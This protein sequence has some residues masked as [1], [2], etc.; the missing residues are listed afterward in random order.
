MPDLDRPGTYQELDL[1]NMRQRLAGFASQCE[2]AWEE[3]LA[4][5]LPP[6]YARVERAVVVGMGGSAIGGD[7]LADLASQEDALPIVVSRDYHAPSYV[8]EDTLVIACSYSGNTEETLSAFGQA[9]SRSA[10]VVA[11]TSGGTLAA[12]ASERGVPCF[13]FD[14]EGEPRS[15]LG[16]LFLAPLAIFQKLG[17]LRDK[18][19][20]LAGAVQELNVLRSRWA[21]D[22]PSG[23]NEAKGLARELLGRVVVVYGSGIFGGVARRWKT[24]LDENSKVWAFWEMLPEAHH[25][26]VVGYSLP[27]EMARLAYALL[28]RPPYQHPQMARRYQVTRELLEREG[29]PSRVVEG[30]G[31]SALAQMLTAV[32]LGDYVS[33]YL[34]TLQGID[35]SPVPPIDFIKSRLA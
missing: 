2:S 22:V 28:L 16:Y 25:N 5:T 14:Y 10:K 19:G 21:E 24:Q 31:Q 33:Y 23:E 20:D 18:S 27:Q 29:I 13:V 8:D 1:T 6:E 35:P 4:F 11:V 34:A 17:L 32:Y 9:L 12:Q 3:A 26:S 15:A 7:L 30:W